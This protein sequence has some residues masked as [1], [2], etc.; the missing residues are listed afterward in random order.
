MPKFQFWQS[1]P[2]G[3]AQHRSAPEEPTHPWHPRGSVADDKTW[4]ANDPN[5]T[6]GNRFA[7]PTK[8]PPPY[9]GC[10]QPSS[11]SEKRQS[12]TPPA[13]RASAPAAPRTPPPGRQHYLLRAK[14]SIPPPP[15]NT[16]PPQPT[17]PPPRTEMTHRLRFHRLRVH[18]HGPLMAI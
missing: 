10:Q 13:G 3:S 7:P 6:A 12:S 14:A 17:R 8:S 15:D 11:G 16:I 1:S 9:Q 2:R 5:A 4:G 18:S